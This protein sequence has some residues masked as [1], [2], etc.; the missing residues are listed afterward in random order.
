MLRPPAA[1]RDSDGGLKTRGA[2]AASV[3]THLLWK[4]KS[5][6]NSVESV[7]PR[8]TS[9]NDADIVIEICP[10]QRPI[11]GAVGGWRGW[12]AR[13]QVY[14]DGCAAEKGLFLLHICSCTAVDMRDCRS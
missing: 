6:R 3:L 12:R 1:E 2:G 11:G 10:H 9:G 7:W 8:L 14:D 4:T 5:E 13:L